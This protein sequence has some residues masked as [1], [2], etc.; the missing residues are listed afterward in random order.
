MFLRVPTSSSLLTTKTST[1]FLRLE[2]PSHSV[3]NKIRPFGE[4]FVAFYSY[5]LL[6]PLKKKKKIWVNTLSTKQEEW[7]LLVFS[8]CLSW[9]GISTSAVSWSKGD[10]NL[11]TQPAVPGWCLFPVSGGWGKEWHQEFSLCSSE[12]EG[13]RNPG[14]LSLGV[15]Y[16]IPR[17]GVQERESPIFLVTPLEAEFQS[18]ILAVLGAGMRERV[19]D[20]VPQSL[21][22]VTK[23]QQIFF[24]KYFLICCMPLAPVPKI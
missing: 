11:W 16:G 6:P 8:V 18:T 21:A 20:Q 24:N 15:R 10:Q 2:I 4:I 13:M 1:P 19:M 9:H 22:I 7:Q 14:S 17:L 5:G 12:W 3:S 23:F